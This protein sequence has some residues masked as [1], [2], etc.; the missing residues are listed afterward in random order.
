MLHAYL[1]NKPDVKHLYL[2]A[3][4]CAGQNK[5]NTIVGYLA[6]RIIT[7][8]NEQ[9]TFSFM[10]S[11]HTKNE[12]DALF[13]RIKRELYAQSEVVAPRQ[14]VQVVKDS[15]RRVDVT[16]A[17]E[18]L[19]FDWQGFLGQ[20]FKKVVGLNSKRVLHLSS[21]HPAVVLMAKDVNMAVSN[22]DCHSLLKAGVS[23]DAVINP[24]AHQLRPLSDFVLHTCR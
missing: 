23:I 18:M 21:E 14:L 8:R 19:W 4:N 20:F 5:N 3:D 10:V 17:R 22:K 15:T 1:E 2:H 11:G 7:G 16:T 24:R 9:I 6:W 12:C 13:G